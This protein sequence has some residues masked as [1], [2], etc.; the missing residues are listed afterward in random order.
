MGEIV[1]LR[2]IKKLLTAA[3]AQQKAKENRVRYGRTGGEKAND[4]R[5]V[6]RTQ[7]TL[8]GKRVTPDPDG[9]QG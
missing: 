7:A 3:A 2:R 4:R 9:D 6:E 5:E 8:R 1:N